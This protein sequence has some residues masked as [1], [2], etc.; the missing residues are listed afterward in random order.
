MKIIIII[1]KYGGFC[2]RFFQ[3]LHYHAFSIENNIYF[4]NPSL[5]GLLRFDNSFYYFCDKVNNFFLSILAKFIKYLF[6][7]D[8]ICF[9]LN[10]NNY[11]KIVNGWNFRENSLTIKY[12]KELK[13]IYDFKKKNNTNKIKLLVNYLEKLKKKGKYLVGLHIRRNDYK[14]WKDGKYYFSDEYYEF[15][16]KKIRL[17]LVN[18]NKNPFIIV[19]SDEKIS[20]NL[21]FDYLSNGSWKEDQIIL[22]SCEILIGPPS[23]FSMWASYISQIP[24]IKLYS[25][26]MKSFNE[27]K[28]CDG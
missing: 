5:L 28:V 27:G 26:E 10:E 16:I 25:N 4:F 17:D 24:L 1:E 2:N 13:E 15:V 14:L 7:K 18:K 19:V 11:I 3:S 9:Y 8:N 22:Q 21:G 12:H 6:G 20:S 23:T